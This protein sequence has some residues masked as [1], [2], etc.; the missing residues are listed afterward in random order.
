MKKLITTILVCLLW[1][2]N[3]WAQCSAANLAGSGFFKPEQANLIGCDK[4]AGD[5]VPSA[6]GTYDLGTSSKEWQDLYVDGTANIDT[7]DIGTASITSITSSPVLS[8]GKQPVLT[9]ATPVAAA[10]PVAGTN[11]IKGV[12]APVPSV[13][14]DAAVLLPTP[15]SAGERWTVTNEGANAIRIK[16]GGTNTIN[17]S[18]AG[19]YIPLATQ[20]VADCIATTKSAWRCGTLA[21]PTPAGP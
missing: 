20:A 3:A 18:S 1:S 4:L 2:G 21:V 5:L 17:G 6:D 10:T 12:I 9:V 8:V 11:T 14:A 7:A 15:A 16:A 19:G 13:A